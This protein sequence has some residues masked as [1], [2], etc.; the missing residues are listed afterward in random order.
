[1]AERLGITAQCAPEA[2]DGRL[3]LPKQHAEPSKSHALVRWG[4]DGRK[5]MKLGQRTDA[6]TAACVPASMLAAMGGAGAEVSVE[7]IGFVKRVRYDV[8]LA[9]QVLIALLTAVAA[10]FGVIGTYLSSSAEKATNF[11]QDTAMVILVV[12][13][14][15]AVAKL[16]KDLRDA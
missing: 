16:V 4:A 12:A 9:L 3:L 14:V 7:P 1:M 10:G 15:L 2:A 13:A 5:V 8:D 11:E 6:G